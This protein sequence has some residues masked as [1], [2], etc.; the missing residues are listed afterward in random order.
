MKNLIVV[1][2]FFFY[3]QAIAQIVDIPDL[4]FRYALIE[5]GFD[6][7]G[8]GKMQES[9]VENIQYLNLTQK[10]ISSLQGIKS[11]K[12]LSTLLLTTNKLSSLD[13]RQY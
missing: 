2:L 4:N 10:N 9:E 13:L 1:L 12:N 6:K 7:N 3:Q 11:F 8:D 5:Q